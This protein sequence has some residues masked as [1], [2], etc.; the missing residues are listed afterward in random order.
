MSKSENKNYIDENFKWFNDN[1]NELI[2]KYNLKNEDIVIISDK[3]FVA[4]FS[5][6]DEANIYS[7]ENL[8]DKKFIVQKISDLDP[9]MNN[10]GYVGLSFYA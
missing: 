10:F 4:K 7:L 8:S 2:K 5:N 9:K 3:K 1:K 6:Y